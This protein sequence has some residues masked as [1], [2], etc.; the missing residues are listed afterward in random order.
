VSS[1]VKKEKKKRKKKKKKK[2]EEGIVR[3]MEGLRK[4]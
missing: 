3:T 1:Q 2:E 4:E